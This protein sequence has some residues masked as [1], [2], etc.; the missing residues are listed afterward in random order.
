MNKINNQLRG[1]LR[2]GFIRCVFQ[3]PYTMMEL[4]V[5]LRDSVFNGVGFA[6]C[7]PND[8]WRDNLGYEIAC[9]RAKADIVR[10]IR[11]YEDNGIY[12]TTLK[13]RLERVGILEEGVNEQYAEDNAVYL[14]NLG[15]E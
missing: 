9:G 2:F 14:Q 13:G 4:Q 3:K 11:T 15:V 1:S 12:M 6:K 8:E 5:K 7:H 10:Q